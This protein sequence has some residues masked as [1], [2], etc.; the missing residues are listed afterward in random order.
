METPLLIARIALL[1]TCT[2]VL[3]P[4]LCAQTPSVLAAALSPGTDTTTYAYEFTVSDTGSRP[5]N[6][7][8]RIDP[9]RPEGQRV[10]ILEATGEDVDTKEID[11]RMEANADG[12]IWC[13]SM[14]SGA[15]GAVTEQPAPAGQRA[16]AFT[17]MAR[18]DAESEERKIFSRLSATAFVDEETGA[19][20]S[21]RAVLD[22]PW[23]PNIMAKISQFEL[24]V[25]CAMAPNGRAYAET[26]NT[27]ISG[28]ALGQ[29]F[30][31]DNTRRI[32]RVYTPG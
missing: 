14:F 28:S 32:T 27:K 21:S 12:D 15:D 13:D 20:K 31:S 16:Y 2:A 23:K 9:S 5:M 10:E 25:E 17:P 4:A 6:L 7:R 30:T 8:G 22:K 11:E 19:L 1:S 26:I 24:S 29:N 3:T 18:P